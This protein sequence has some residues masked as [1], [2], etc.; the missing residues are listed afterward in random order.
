M[1]ILKKE[2]VLRKEEM[3]RKRIGELSS[4]NRYEFYK[5]ANRKIKDPDTY[6]VLNYLI[7]IGLHHFYLGK[8]VLGLLNIAI[9]AAG[10]IMLFH[11]EL[12]GAHM[13][14]GILIFELH[15]LFR[16]QII[17]KDHNNRV[18]EQVYF[19]ITGSS[20]Y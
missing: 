7:I 6:A 1:G 19:S 3:L 13:V 17:V 20:P 18:K 11:G 10:I 4:D 14:W 12:I 15:Q 5:R 16:S 9:F 2:E 8:W